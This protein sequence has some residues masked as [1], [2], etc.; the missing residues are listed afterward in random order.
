MIADADQVEV[1]SWV[2]SN[3]AEVVAFANHV[4]GLTDKDA[5]LTLTN[6]PATCWVVRNGQ[7]EGLHWRINY[8]Y[9]VA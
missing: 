1:Y 6:V 7:P 5:T 8:P 3:S 2:P 4:L 9:T